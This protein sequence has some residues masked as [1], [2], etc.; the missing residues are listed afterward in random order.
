MTDHTQA[1]QTVYAGEGAFQ[2]ASFGG[3]N[4]E[5]A[6]GTTTYTVDG[7]EKTTAQIED[8]LRQ[9]AVGAQLSVAYAFAGTGNYAGASA[10]GTITVTVVRQ[11]TNP[12]TDVPSGAY[13]EEAVLWAVGEGV[14]SG[15]SATTFTPDGSCT[16]AQAV[17]FLWRIA[18]RPAPKTGTMP[19]ADVKTGAYYYDAVLWAM[20]N[21]ITYGTSAVAFSPDATCTRAQIVSFLYRYVGSPAV[22]SG[23]VFSDVGASAYYAD[24]VVWAATSGVAAG[25]GGGKFAPDQNCTRAQIV[26][27]IYRMQTK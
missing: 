17:S 21:G 24:A 8:L 2:T 5:T 23:A 22:Q 14:T 18:G 20:E 7:Q 16:R 4:G 26:S 27:F 9:S 6:T 3:V 15:T 11:V 13:Y 25:I 12:F 19:F 1:A 10:S